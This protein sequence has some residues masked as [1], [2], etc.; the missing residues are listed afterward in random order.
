VI[1]EISI[2]VIELQRLLLVSYSRFVYTTVVAFFLKIAP[3][4]TPVLEER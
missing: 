3:T 4:D 1:G 2:D